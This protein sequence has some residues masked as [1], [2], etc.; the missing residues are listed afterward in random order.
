MLS[1]EN[2]QARNI[3]A[4][5]SGQ[6][7][8]QSTQH[9]MNANFGIPSVIGAAG[10]SRSEYSQVQKDIKDPHYNINQLIDYS[11]KEFPDRRLIMAID[12]L[13]KRDPE[14]IRQTLQD[15]RNILHL[16]CSFILTGHPLGVLR[17]AYTTA[18][19]IFDKEVELRVF[20]A[21]E[22]L[23]MIENYLE[24]G[25]I[26]QNNK[27]GLKPFTNEVAKLIIQ[28][29]FGIPRVINSICDHI[30]VEASR[31]KFVKID[32]EELAI[33][34]RAANKSL[35]RN[36][37]LDFRNLLETLL[38]YSE[39]ISPTDTPD[40][41]FEKLNLD[42]SSDLI[43]KLDAAVRGDVLVNTGDHYVAHP[44][45][46]PETFLTSTQLTTHFDLRHDQQAAAL[47]QGWRAQIENAANQ[48]RDTGLAYVRKQA[49]KKDIIDYLTEMSQKAAEGE[50]PGSPWL[51]VA[52]LC[53]ALIALIKEESI[54]PVPAAYTS[55]FLAVQS[56][57][58]R[59]KD[60]G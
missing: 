12:D 36:I 14:T 30:L 35:K 53:E 43:A 5:I 42:S 21:E 16:N 41:V 22:G 57:K 52:A 50:K 28:S 9:E 8:G 46:M 24:A 18:G 33:C 37:N 6:E 48:A 20:S 31:R 27:A 55:H 10:I 60:E 29:S 45:M 26:N 23:Q 49:P 7:S 17:D 25:R 38:S 47:D 4:V 1:D 59:M 11:S 56:E 58:Q 19:G 39:G 32:I 15:A 3:E 34:W 13:D 44:L 51:E 40:E 2:V 54:P